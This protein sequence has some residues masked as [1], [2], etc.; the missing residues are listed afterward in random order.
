MTYIGAGPENKGIGLFSQDTFTG[1][2]S[3]TTFDM[4]NAA[5]DGG[6]NDVQVFVDNVRQQEGASNA[7]TIG[8][9]GS[10]DFKRITFTAAPA[11]S[12]SIFVLNPGTKNTLQITTISD[13]TISTAKL[14]ATSVTTAKLGADA[15]TGAKIA[16]DAVDSEHFVDGSIDTAHIGNL[17]V[18][19]AKIAAD[20]IDATKLA[21]DAVS[22][23]HLDATAISGQTELTDVAADTDVLL[24]FDTTAGALRK[25]QR[26]KVRGNAPTITSISPTAVASG[27][28]TGNYT[29]TITGTNYFAGTTANLKTNGGSNIAFDTV[30][31]D[32]TTQLTCVVAKNTANLTHAN[33]PFDVVVTNGDGTVTLENQ[34]TVDGSPI[35]ST[36]AGSLGTFSEQTATGNLDIVAH[37]PDSGGNVS[38]EFQ[39]GSLPPGLSSTTV[40]ENGV[41]KF[42][43][44]GTLSTDRSSSTTTNFTIRAFDAASNT[45]SRAFSITETPSG[46]QSFTSSGTF[47]VPTGITNLDVLVVAGGGSGGGFS[48]GRGGGGAGGLIFAPDHPVT[49]GGTITVTVGDGGTSSGSGQDSV[50]GTLT[51]KGGGGRGQAGGSGGGGD[52]GVG[53]GAATQPTQPGSS[54][55][56]GFGNAGAANSPGPNAGGGGGGAGQAGSQG[57]QCNAGSGGGGKNFT[58]ADGTTSVGYAGGGGGGMSATSIFAGGSGGNSG[59]PQAPLFGGGRGGQGN[60]GGP[61]KSGAPAQA[62][63]GGGGG[64]AAQPAG[65]AGNGGKGIVIVHF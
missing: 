32:S 37:D 44:S 35:F 56:Y 9:D 57:G 38:F 17:Q 55:A 59:C 45:A 21:D 40:H 14:Q 31:I 19:T 26:S 29:F 61:N 13:N 50:F 28:G 11:A 43:I 12:A 5:P 3:T 62:N 27:D 23:E 22:D 49:P 53:P 34:V 48:P 7:Y 33:E 52:P 24:I 2:G 10:G 42:R 65:S 58:I 63:R 8:Q 36:A 1:D 47:S 25:I 64:G 51:A 46:R 41:S 54:G 20:A 39:S 4:T 60:N 16:D 15:V 6:G 30:T 18:T